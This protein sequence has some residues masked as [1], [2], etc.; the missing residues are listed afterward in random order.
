MDNLDD[1]IKCS[2]SLKL[3]Y[4]E[5]SKETRIST[6]TILE[7][8]F[9]DIVV[10]VDGLDGLK[11]FRNNN[12]D[13][14]IT[15]INMPN[16]NGLQMVKK[17][18]K[19]EKNIPVFIFSAHNETN[20]FIDAI[21]LGVEAYLLKPFDIEQF[22]KALSRCIKNINLKKENLEYKNSLELKIN[23]QLE[24]LRQKDKIL[25]QQSKM[26]AIGEM[27]DAIAHQW[28]QPL[29]VI[30]LQSELLQLDLAMNNINQK[31]IQ[32]ATD[33]TIEQ[34]HHLTDTIDEFRD[35]FRP[36]INEK[37]INLKSLL[38]SIIILLKD[39]LV[40]HSIKIQ[41]LCE[42]GIYIKATKNDI[43]HL[44]INLINNAKD[45]M[46]KSN[47]D[48]SSRDI[49]IQCIKNNDNITITVKD[50]GNG[51]SQNIIK[52]IFE[53][54]ITTKEDIGGTGIGLYISSMIVEKYKGTIEVS[55]NT[56]INCEQSLN[57]ALFTIIFPND[58]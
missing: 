14:I 45:E 1:I 2:T 12:I 8:F 6:L 23:E 22:T 41:F 51:V 13:I 31:N 4:V 58:E 19:I 44:I 57:G 46:V 39:E 32:I 34:I 11:K 42:D 29:S 54:H 27:I 35:F 21:K 56:D 48:L 3:L 55:N 24:D 38:N 20:L 33:T 15:D 36:T 43:K 52:D 28:K 7:E 47:I 5:D 18:K 16:L 40:K 9:D 37:S 49:K 17:I 30:K 26:A 53:P 50:N 10:A 25:L